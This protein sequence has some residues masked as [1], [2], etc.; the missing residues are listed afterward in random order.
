[1]VVSGIPLGSRFLAQDEISV[2]HHVFSELHL[3][4]TH[5]S[6]KNQWDRPEVESHLEKPPDL[7]VLGLLGP[8]SV[9]R[10][11]NLALSELRDS[12]TLGGHLRL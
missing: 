6:R 12:A 1:M 4:L 9:S 11:A 5:G 7:E 10:R 8:L 3:L 2:Q